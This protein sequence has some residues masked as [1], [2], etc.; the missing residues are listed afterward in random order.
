MSI[1]HGM[2]MF[3]MAFSEEE[4]IETLGRMIGIRLWK[5]KY[6]HQPIQ[7]LF[8]KYSEIEQ[9]ENYFSIPI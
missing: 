4:K 8:I 2:N 1:S 9:L 3:G 5:V 7:E 6:Y